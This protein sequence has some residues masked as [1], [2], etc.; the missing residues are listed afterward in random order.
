M[1]L[2]KTQTGEHYGGA[3]DHRGKLCAGPGGRDQGLQKHLG[4]NIHWLQSRLSAW[5]NNNLTAEGFNNSHLR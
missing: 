4:E 5:S 3:A 2:F 1:I